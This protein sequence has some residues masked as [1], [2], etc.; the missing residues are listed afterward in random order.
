MFIIHSGIELPSIKHNGEEDI[1]SGDHFGILGG[2]IGGIA[3]VLTAVWKGI[4]LEKRLDKLEGRVVYK[5]VFNEFRKTQ[6][7]IKASNSKEHE[8]IMGVLHEL[9]TRIKNGK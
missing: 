3:A 6:E 2:F 5:D 8:Q 4:S 7:E 1:M 9:N